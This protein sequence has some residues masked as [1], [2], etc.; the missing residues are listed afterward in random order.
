MKGFQK[1]SFEL[2][3]AGVKVLMEIHWLSHDT[4]R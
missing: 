4:Y 3:M 1:L 2:V